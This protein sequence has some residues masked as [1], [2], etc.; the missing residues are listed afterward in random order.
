MTAAKPIASVPLS[1]RVRPMASANVCQFRCDTARFALTY[2]DALETLPQSK[3]RKLFKLM[4]SDPWQNA[5]AICMTKEA[6]TERVAETHAAWDRASSD[7]VNGW[8]DAKYRSASEQ[9]RLAAVNKKL[10]DAVKS[11]KTKHERAQ[12]LLAYF[13]SL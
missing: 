6:L 8:V 1:L 5:A 9:R 13:E 11:A 3:L 10:T 2:P 7:F 4:V 12:K